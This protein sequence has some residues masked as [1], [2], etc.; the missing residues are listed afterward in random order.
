MNKLIGGKTTQ[1][2][3]KSTTPYSNWPKIR[4]IPNFSFFG[5]TFHNVFR[6]NTI[7]N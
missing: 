7:T 4:Y 6:I 2:E 5:E 3:R 1:P